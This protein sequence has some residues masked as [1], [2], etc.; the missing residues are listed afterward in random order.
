MVPLKALV[1]DSVS[2]PITRRVYNLG[3]N[4]FSP[5]TSGS[6]APAS[7]FTYSFDRATGVYTR[8]AASL[9]PILTERAETIGKDRFLFGFSYQHFVFNSIDSVSLRDVPVIFQ[10][11]PTTNTEY[12]KDIITTDNYI[13]PQVG[14]FTSFLT[15]GLTN[16]LD[17]SVAIPLMSVSLA[18]TS[19]AVIQRIGTGG[20]KEIHTFGTP[21]GGLEETFSAAASATGIGDVIGR[22]KGTAIKWNGGGL[23]GVVDL[24][25]PTGDEYNFLGSGA[26]GVRG[27][28]VVSGQ[29]GP[30][31]PHGNVGYEWNGESVL[32][33]NVTAGTKSKLPGSVI[34]QGGADLRL[35]PKMTFAADF[36]GERVTADRVLSKSFI[37]ANGQ[38]FPAIAFQKSGY[39]LMSGSTGFKIN[40]TGN[41]IVTVNALFRLNH[42]GLHSKVVP[43]IGISYTL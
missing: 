15:Y 40:P 38:T 22:V 31:A 10:H 41:L 4:E 12:I 39:S 26:L 7:G 23:A 18:A 14:Q 21:N 33:G 19:H 30:L 16:R 37:A 11:A 28:A 42:A 9:G 20:Q 13:D 17:V 27:F 43:L 24:R 8:S 25:L 32:A 3:L 6:L 36:F 35:T 5:G 2:S 34:Y 29:L 1:L